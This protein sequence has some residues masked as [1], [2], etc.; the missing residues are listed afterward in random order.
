MPITE[1]NSKV[2]KIEKVEVKPSDTT[3]DKNVQ[4]KVTPEETNNVFLQ[5]PLD[6]VTFN[7]LEYQHISGGSLGVV[8]KE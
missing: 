6:P 1:K 7:E 2:V 3:E 8:L 4:K 5:I